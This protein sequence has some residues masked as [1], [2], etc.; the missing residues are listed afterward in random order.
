[1]ISF[2]VVLGSFGLLTA[3]LALVE[4]ITFVRNDGGLVGSVQI[5]SLVSII[6]GSLCKSI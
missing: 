3:A 6:F 4:L 2:S 1:L 5:V